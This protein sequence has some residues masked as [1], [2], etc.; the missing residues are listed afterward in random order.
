M[1]K[2]KLS[3]GCLATLVLSFLIGFLPC[4]I[5]GFGIT[6]ALFGMAIIAFG[7]YLFTHE[8]W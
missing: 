8:D 1:S 5:M 6:V 7:L 3:N 2:D 4:L